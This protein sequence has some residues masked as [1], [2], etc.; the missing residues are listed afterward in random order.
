MP[1]MSF[2][3]MGLLLLNVGLIVGFMLGTAW[4]PST[5]QELPTA[6]PHTQPL[7][8]EPDVVSMAEAEEQLVT[9]IYE[10]ISPSVVHITSVTEV[11]DFFRG[12]V[13]REGTGSG[14]VYDTQGHIITN[15]HVI[16]DAQD[17]SILLADGTTLPAQV[18]G[19]D[20]YYDVAV[21][22]V[23]PARLN[24]P[25]APLATA[26]PLRVGQRVLAIGNP[27][28]LDRT[29]TTGVISALN[30]TIQ[31]ESGLVVG[32]VI[33][34]DAAINPG[35]S[36]GPLLDSR[37]RVIGINTAITTP[38]GGSVGIG[39]AVPIDVA[40]RVVPVLISQGRFFHPSLNIEVRELG[41]EISPGDMGVQN[42]LL[43][44]N[45]MPGGSAAQAGLQPARV[46][47]GFFQRYYVGGDVITAINGVPMFTRDA[48][49]LY[50]EENLRP[51]DP[52]TVTIAREGQT[53]DIPVTIG[54]R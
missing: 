45:V 41:F 17:I 53:L 31:G 43:I 29:L 42:G 12:T 26:Q 44:V 7:A 20:S 14:F 9:Q 21:L 50:L 28:G 54:Q 18:V 24:A 11:F 46:E 32:N 5:A 4:Q 1:R 2:K 10:Q 8:L 37:G 16:S 51:G 47:G 35:N 38:S 36:G 33:Q 27:F 22:R 3:W 23:D 30:R 34:T 39:F 13:P 49:V 15:N 48:M 52:A 25:P 19:G 6:T 40:A